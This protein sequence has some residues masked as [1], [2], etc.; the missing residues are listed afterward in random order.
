VSA[1]NA[2]LF[3]MILDMDINKN[4]KR[5][6]VCP[7]EICWHNQKL[8]PR[9]GRVGFITTCTYWQVGCLRST[10]LLP[11]SAKGAFAFGGRPAIHETS[12]ASHLSNV[13]LKKPITHRAGKIICFSLFFGYASS[14]VSFHSSFSRMRSI[15]I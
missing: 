3:Y 15:N 11:T 13:G 4:E 10:S 8:D 9:S 7:A 12:P 14:V 2:V 5:E 1:G 6:H